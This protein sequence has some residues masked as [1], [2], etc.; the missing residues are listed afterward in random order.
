[1]N[2]RKPKDNFRNH[3]QL[4]KQPRL[5]K[6]PAPKT[7][8]PKSFKRTVEFIS[9][10]NNSGSSEADSSDYELMSA[11]ETGKSNSSHLKKD[12]LKSTQQVT[13]P[14]KKTFEAGCQTEGLYLSVNR[15][16]HNKKIFK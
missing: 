3:D 10:R 11:I 14:K 5:L 16:E 12:L 6:K 8:E 2:K 15:N 9:P 7:L 4:A 13:K 1:M